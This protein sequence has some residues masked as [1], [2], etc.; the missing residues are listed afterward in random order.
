MPGLV[1]GIHVFL[2]VSKNVDGRDE[3]GH[4]GDGGTT[5]HLTMAIADKLVLQRQHH[6]KWRAFDRLALFLMI[7]WGVLWFGFLLSVTADIVTRTIRSPWLWLP[8]DTST[9]FIYALFIRAPRSTRRNAHL[10]L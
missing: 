5:E 2:A 3:P 8:E 7:V 9:L 10:Y 4:D 1:P 6:L